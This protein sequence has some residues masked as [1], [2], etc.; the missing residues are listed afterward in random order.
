MKPG[1]A[2]VENELYYAD[3]CQMVFG[4]AKAVIEKLVAALKEQ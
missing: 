2:G 1:Y 4:D 3:N